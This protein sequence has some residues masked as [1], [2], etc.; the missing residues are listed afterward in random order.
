[1]LNSPLYPGGK[2]KMTHYLKF[3]LLLSILFLEA[4]FI[5]SA[6][7]KE[8]SEQ[9]SIQKDPLEGLSEDTKVGYAMGYHYMFLDPHSKKRYPYLDPKIFVF[10]F[11]EGL[12]NEHI[13]EEFDE[14]ELD[15]FIEY[16]EKRY[17]NK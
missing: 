14:A 7:S 16:Y 2:L 4:L 11:K 3:F 17:K 5:T 8:K 13:V 10:A 6:F 15:D 1:M 9:I 12:E